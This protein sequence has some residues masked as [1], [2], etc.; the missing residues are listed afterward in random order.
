MLSTLNV[1]ILHENLWKKIHVNFYSLQ[2]VHTGG[3]R[4]IKSSC[5]I[6][7]V[8]HFAEKNCESESWYFIPI[9][10]Q[11]RRSFQQNHTPVCNGMKF[12]AQESI[13]RPTQP[14]LRWVPGALSLWVKRT[15]REDN[16][17][18]PPST[19]LKEWVE[20]HLNNPIRLQGMVFSL[21]KAKRQLHIYIPYNRPSI[22]AATSFQWRV[23]K[24][25]YEERTIPSIITFL[26]VYC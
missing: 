2:N 9:S 4:K 14:P 18:N 7:R 11:E 19:E 15:R 12:M 17:L 10:L 23:T 25:S 22:E 16:H 1:I 3:R 8:M 26:V 21:K 24:C 5:V 20:L 6:P 13:M